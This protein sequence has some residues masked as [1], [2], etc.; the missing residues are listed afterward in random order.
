L[1]AARE[2]RRRSISSSS[3]RRRSSRELTQ[4]LKKNKK[5]HATTAT[6]ENIYTRGTCQSTCESFGAD[7]DNQRAESAFSDIGKIGQ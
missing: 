7:N 2:W 5:R 6:G 3:K 4:K 1:L